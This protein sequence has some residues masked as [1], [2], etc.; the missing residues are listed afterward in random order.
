MYN[1]VKVFIFSTCFAFACIANGSKLVEADNPCFNYYGRT[2]FSD[3]KAPVMYWTGS[4]I[5]TK[6]SGNELSVILDDSGNNR[7]NIMIDRDLAQVDVIRCVKG[8]HTYKYSK[9]LSDG[10]HIVTIFRRN[11]LGMGKTI[12]HGIIIGSNDNI[13]SIPKP[14][15]K[16][17]FYGDS[18]TCGLGNEDISRKRNFD[19]SLANNYLAYSS[20]TA[21][22]LNADMHLI[23]KGGI[24]INC[25]FV[26]YV[27]SDI[28]DR[29]DPLNPK[30]L[31]WDF[32][33]WQADIVVI[34]LFQNDSILFGQK[35]KHKNFIKRFPSGV[36]PGSDY[37]IDS[38][39]NFVEKLIAVYPNASFICA[40]GSM[41]A[42]K[43]GSPWPGYIKKAVEKLKVRNKKVK[44][45]TLFFPYKNTPGHPNVSEHKV[46]ADSLTQFIKENI[47]NYHSR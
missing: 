41:S 26:P 24:G 36:N 28:Y 19:K 22:N 23:A 40:L 2:N 18:I 33:Q 1:Q 17:E 4:Y 29:L 3:P 6:F 34:N 9:K 43:P 5:E 14:K 13:F 47:L 15:L 11:D 16:I 37:I 44:L 32:S 38:Y 46:M 35:K 7:Y 8:K 10:K 20:M 12:F 39:V 25:G 21:R 27:I 45:S 42:T 31:K 30:S